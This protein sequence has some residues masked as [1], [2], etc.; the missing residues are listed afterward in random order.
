M[1]SSRSR[2]PEPQEK[3]RALR[4]A[5]SCGRCWQRLFG[6]LLQV[7]DHVGA[8]LFLLEAD[9]GHLGA[10]H[11]APRRFEV[12][13]ERGLV[14]HMTVGKLSHALGVLEDPDARRRPPE[15]V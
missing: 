3:S 14:P 1:L 2:T 12:A 11:D 7:G 8:V 6:E 10:L 15:K 5:F 13:A 9:E 4:P